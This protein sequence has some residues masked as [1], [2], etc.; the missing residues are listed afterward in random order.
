[1]LALK[2]ISKILDEMGSSKFGK[3][4]IKEFAGH[5]LS[6]E[7][8]NLYEAITILNII[9]IFL[10]GD[11]TTDSKE[12]QKQDKDINK[13]IF[14][15]KYKLSEKHIET[16]YLLAGGLSI[17]EITDEISKQSGRIIEV[18][19]INKRLQKI[20]RSLGVHSRAE[21]VCKAMVEGLL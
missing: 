7:D 12:G 11:V 1:M 9:T 2:D 5:L 8:R 16:L 18:S 6:K 15:E 14:K 3:M 4:T 13:L 17:D 19:T 20:Y 10:Y 21:A